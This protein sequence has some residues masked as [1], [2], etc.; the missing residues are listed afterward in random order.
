[1]RLRSVAMSCALLAA[2]A[3]K[4][5]S[6]EGPD[7][8]SGASEDMARFYFDLSQPDL[9]GA[10]LAVSQTPDLAFGPDLLALPDLTAVPDLAPPSDFAGA[11]LAC[12]NACNAPPAAK[13]QANVLVTYAN[14]GACSNGMCAY[15][16]MMSNCV[17]GCYQG[18]CSMAG[19]SFC[20]NVK[21]FQT[22]GPQ[23][24]IGPNNPG[25]TAANVTVSVTVETFPHGTV[26]AAHL[27]WDTN[28]Q[29]TASRD[30]VMTFDKEVGNN[31]QWFAVIP[32]QAA[33]TQVWFYVR[34][35]GYDNSTAYAQKFGENYTY[36]SK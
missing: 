18:A 21:G 5:A 28:A 10:D 34:A 4:S 15:A 19:L 26:A 2:C 16:A 27:I 7:D 30:I 14:P 9:T 6:P 17:H 25:T 1:M 8:L 23:I 35:D 32:A 29:Y 13:C 33:G 20:G 24:G 12:A 11:D 31:D 3:A 22:M 36:I